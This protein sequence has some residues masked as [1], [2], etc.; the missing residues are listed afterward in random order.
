MDSNGNGVGSLMTLTQV[1]AANPGLNV[2]RVYLTLGMGDSY[3]VS[4]GVGT[5]G[6]VDKVTIGGVLY[7][8][9]Q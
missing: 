3:N 6:W 4:S 7:D 8:F 5:V 9:V 2:D 1:A